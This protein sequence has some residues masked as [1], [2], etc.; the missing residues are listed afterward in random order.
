MAAGHS[1]EPLIGGRSISAVDDDES[2]E[3]WLTE[4]THLQPH[5]FSLGSVAKGISALRG[6]QEQLRQLPPQFSAAGVK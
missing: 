1:A 3:V 4:W 6:N 2:D 5:S